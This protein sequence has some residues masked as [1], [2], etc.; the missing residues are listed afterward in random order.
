MN[1]SF[2]IFHLQL[3]KECSLSLLWKPPNCLTYQSLDAQY[4]STKKIDANIK[5]SSHNSLK[6]KGYESYVMESYDLQSDDTV[7]KCDVNLGYITTNILNTYDGVQQKYL[8][9]IWVEIYP[10]DAS[11]EAVEICDEEK[12]VNFCTGNSVLTEEEASKIINKFMIFILEAFDSDFEIEK[13]KR[14][15][16]YKDKSNRRSRIFFESEIRHAVRKKTL[17]IASYFFENGRY[18]ELCYAYKYKWNP[19]A[20][21]NIIITVHKQRQWLRYILSLIKKI[22]LETNDEQLNVIV[23]EFAADETQPLNQVFI[24][25]QLPRYQYITLQQQQHFVKLKGIQAGLDLVQDPQSIVLL[26]DLHIQI[27]NN[28]FELIRKHCIIGKMAFNPIVLRLFS[29]RSSRNPAGYWEIMGFGVMAMYKH[30]WMKLPRLDKIS[31]KSSWGGEDWL[32][33]DYIAKAGIE[34]LRLKVPGFFHYYHSHENLW[35]G[36]NIANRRKT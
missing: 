30:D 35:D 32:V 24:E 11:W 27:P 23:A 21:I 28:F 6:Y 3:V 25:T 7:S 19:K 9:E 12:P 26:M 20:L 8:Q 33:V 1:Y 15:E 34:I 29:G 14:I 16:K 31:T 22:S 18:L 2:E 36:K 4:L 10:R 5:T 17:T 13:I